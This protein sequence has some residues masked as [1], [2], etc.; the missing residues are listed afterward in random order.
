MTCE[1][2][3]FEEMQKKF[4]VNE[5]KEPN[6]SF[7]EYMNPEFMVRQVRN[8]TI[9]CSPNPVRNGEFPWW[10]IWIFVAF[11]ILAIL[12]WLIWLCFPR[13]CPKACVMKWCGWCCCDC[14]RKCCTTQ[15]CC[16]PVNP[17]DTPLKHSDRKD[18]G[19]EQ[20]IFF[21]CFLLYYFFQ[22]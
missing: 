5:Y 20:G 8:S 19:I 16:S 13:C 18:A 12:I 4:F 11:L 21:T 3:S 6:T 22:I 15:G 7:I 2:K 10:I 14:C 1:N 17:T 9:T